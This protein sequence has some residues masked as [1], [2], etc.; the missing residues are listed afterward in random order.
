MPKSCMSTTVKRVVIMERFIWQMT[1]MK[2]KKALVMLVV[3]QSYLNGMVVSHWLSR[4]A[5]LAA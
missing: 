3:D 2:M 4:K 5:S 1:H